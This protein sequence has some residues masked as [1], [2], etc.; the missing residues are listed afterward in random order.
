MICPIAVAGTGKS[1]FGK[2]LVETGCIPA[3]A[4]VSLDLLRTQTTG[5][6]DDFSTNDEVIGIASTIVRLRL[7][8]GLIVY[9]DSTHLTKH[10]R[11]WSTRIAR[12]YGASLIWVRFNVDP[13]E[14]K[15]R[16]RARDLVVPEA[17][18]ERQISDYYRIDWDALEPEGEVYEI[19]PADPYVDFG[20]F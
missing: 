3:D 8:R 15:R 20:W 14:A 16:N 17:V 2:G 1:T 6:I 10:A 19:D 5:A 13:E 18:M 9:M 11:D 12:T 4:V 7:E